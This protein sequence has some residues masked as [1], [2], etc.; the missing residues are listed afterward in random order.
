MT[1]IDISQVALD[2]PRAIAGDLPVSWELRDVLT[3][4]PGVDRFDLVSAQFMHAVT[5][6]CRLLFVVDSCPGGHQ[7]IVRF[8]LDEAGTPSPGTLFYDFAP[9]RGGDGI[10]L[11]LDG[12]LYVAA[13]INTPRNPSEA[14]L[15]PG[16]HLRALAGR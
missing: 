3:W 10:E 9:G 6:D 16:G 8:E 1:A 13:G 14:D 5:Q 7:R 4:E 12:N 2:R 11:D 15:Y